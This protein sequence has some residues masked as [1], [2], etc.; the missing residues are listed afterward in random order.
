MIQSP[1]FVL[2][3]FSYILKMT[4]ADFPPWCCR[5]VFSQYIHHTFVGLMQRLHFLL[6]V[7][8]YQ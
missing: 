8:R 3:K 7:L 6:S 2:E 5:G 4:A 1:L